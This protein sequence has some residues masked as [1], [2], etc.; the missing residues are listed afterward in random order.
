MAFVLT[1]NHVGPYKQVNM[2][3]QSQIGYYSDQYGIWGDAGVEPEVITIMWHETFSMYMDL[4][5][6]LKQ[7]SVSKLKKNIPQAIRLL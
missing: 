1:E 2:Y 6:Q 5:I 4:M 7:A 3:D